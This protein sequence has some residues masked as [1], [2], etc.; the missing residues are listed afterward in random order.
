MDHNHEH[1]HNHCGCGHEHTHDHG[2]EDGCGCHS[3]DHN[4]IYLTLEDN[5]QVACDVLDIFTVMDQEYIAVLPE[6]EEDVFIY[7]FNEDEDGPHLSMIEEEAEFERISQ[8]FLDKF[9]N[10]EE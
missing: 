2:N 9:E 6:G 4:K 5:Q 8:A 3:H 10:Q 1:Q 7:R